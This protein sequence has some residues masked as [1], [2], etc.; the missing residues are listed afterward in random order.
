MFM[1][2]KGYKIQVAIKRVDWLIVERGR[3]GLS[4]GSLSGFWGKLKAFPGW[5]YV[6]KPSFEASINIFGKVIELQA[7]SKFHGQ[8]HLAKDNGP[9]VYPL[10]IN[11]GEFSV[12][13]LT[14]TQG[15]VELNAPSFRDC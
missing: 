3:C 9:D 7:P 13:I 6:C 4:E 15:R 2:S 1:A 11:K 10:K 8:T 12:F 5:C 14:L